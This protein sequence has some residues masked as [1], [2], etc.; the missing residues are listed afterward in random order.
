MFVKTNFKNYSKF[1]N[2]SL[3]SKSIDKIKLNK[4]FYASIRLTSSVPKHD[5]IEVIKKIRNIGVIAH[6][7][8]GKTTTTE[9]MLFYSGFTKNIGNVDDGNTV[10]DYMDQERERGITI[11]S[12]AITF[13]WKNHHFNLIDTPGHVDFTFEV[14]RSLRVLDGAVAIIDASAGV[15]AQTLTVWKQSNKYK[16]PRI[17]YIN[18][19]D[20]TGANFNYCLDSIESKLNTIALPVQIPIGKEK[21]FQGVYDLVT[22]K[23]LIWDPKR[24]LNDGGKIYDVININP[25]DSDYKIALKNRL[26]LIE[27]LAKVNDEFAE[28]I[29][30][31]YNMEFDKMNDNILLDTFIRK[32]CISSLVTPIF[33][34]SSF[35]NISIQPVMDGI[36]KYLPSPIDLEKNNYSP[37]YDKTPFVVCFKII[38]DHQK[39]RKRINSNTSK[40]ILQTNASNTINKFKSEDTENDV[41]TFVRVY[42]GEL[43]AKSKLYNP[44]KDIKESCDKIYVPYSNQLEQVQKITTGNIGIVHGLTK[45]TTGDIL[46]LNKQMYDKASDKMS[47][48]GKEDMQMSLEIANPVFFCTVEA[49]SESEEKRLN[50]ALECLEREDPS[51]KILINEQENLGQTIIQGQ[52]EL[53]LEIVKDRILKE[54]KLKAYFGPLNIAYKEMPTK[55]VVESINF[56]KSLGERKH[57]VNLEMNVHPKRDHKFEGVDFFIQGDNNFDIPIEIIKSLNHGVKSALNKGVLLRYPFVNTHVH[58]TKMETSRNVPLPYLSS[59][60]YQCTMNALKKAECVVIQPIMFLEVATT[61]EFSSKVYSDLNRRNSLNITVNELN[62]N[63]NIQAKIPL[64]KLSTYS[65]DIRK[66]TSGNATFTIE[67]DSYDQ[68]SQREFQDLLEKKNF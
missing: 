22:M 19:M 5:E 36:I 44:F 41:L 1:L 57:Y 27:K 59:A 34:G 58:L 61:K 47:K 3:N 32:S 31:K 29:L 38:H 56:E 12:A 21:T 37:F 15:E 65:S 63:V 24:A 48:E 6:V 4:F 46:V 25:S 2:I 30:D 16:I 10:M 60:A 68:L 66:L 40:A 54:Y 43:N 52:G 51:L 26:D 13:P 8:A 49:E 67:F 17:A 45:T 28:I 33:C 62:Q 64:A 11:T 42:N 53:H 20:K 18:K 23:K 39:S 35:K 50:Y 7:D 55:S 9:R 14:E